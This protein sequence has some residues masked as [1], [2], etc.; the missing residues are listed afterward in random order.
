MIFNLF[1]FRCMHTLTVLIYLIL[2]NRY[3]NPSPFT[4][5]RRLFYPFE[6]ALQ[7][8]PCYKPEHIAVN[9]PELP[10]GVK[11][12]QH[13][14]GPQ[15]FAIPGNHGRSVISDIEVLFIFCFFMENES[16]KSCLKIW[17]FKIFVLRCWTFMISCIWLYNCH[18]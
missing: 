3:P 1:Y 9:K 8:P 17:I 5:E 12:L 16:S 11:S 6:H 18:H 14:E 10:C 7:P 13:Y 4:Y 15:C 2:L